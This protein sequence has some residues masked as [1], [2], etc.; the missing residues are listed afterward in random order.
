MYAT[1]PFEFQPFTSI[2]LNLD[3]N[4]GADTTLSGVPTDYIH[5]LFLSVGNCFQA[6]TRALNVLARCLTSSVD[7]GNELNVGAEVLGTHTTYSGNSP[8]NFDIESIRPRVPVDYTNPLANSGNSFHAT[9]GTL[10]DDILT[11]TSNVDDIPD[12]ETCA[13]LVPNEYYNL[14]VDYTFDSSM[15]AGRLDGGSSSN[16]NSSHRSGQQI[17]LTDTHRGRQPLDS[18]HRTY[19]LCTNT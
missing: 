16:T 8:T 12:I 3:T 10:A 11:S 14:S 18:L 4:F 5:N 13:S 9:P 1:Q 17:R 15:E 2:P 19:V 6:G 7:I